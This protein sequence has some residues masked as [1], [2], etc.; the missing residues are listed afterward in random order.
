MLHR[1]GPSR[2]LTEAKPA[3]ID[4][5]IAK[6][7]GWFRSGL[8]LVPIWD[9]QNRQRFSALRGLGWLF[10]S[11]TFQSSLRSFGLLDFMKL[12]TAL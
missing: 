4:S 7:L 3:L 11:A 10:S 6:K 2:Q 9:V 12:E 1:C 8:D 5:P